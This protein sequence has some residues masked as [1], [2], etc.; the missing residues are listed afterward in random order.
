MGRVTLDS[1]VLISMYYEGDVYFESVRSFMVGKD[2]SYFI[3]TISLAETLTHA[4]R[5][6]LVPVKLMVERI[7]EAM[8]EIYDVNQEIAVAASMVRAKTDLKMP[9]AIISATATLARTQLWTLDQRMAKAHKGA[10]L[11]GG[12][13]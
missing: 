13:Q 6:G 10:V 1:S 5:K 3:S 4:S 8:T 12:A 9:D 7:N 2:N 11:I